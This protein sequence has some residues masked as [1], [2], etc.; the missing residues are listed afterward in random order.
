MVN[1]LTAVSWF[2]SYLPSKCQGSTLNSYI[3]FSVHQTK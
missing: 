3:S 2:S 1:I